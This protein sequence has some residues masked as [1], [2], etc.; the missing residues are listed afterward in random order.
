MLIVFIQGEKTVV[1]QVHTDVEAELCQDK[2]GAYDFELAMTSLSNL[3]LELVSYSITDI[4]H[5]FIS[6]DL[7]IPEKLMPPITF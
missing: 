3:V 7:A 6:S 5:N 4:N 1:G 2:V